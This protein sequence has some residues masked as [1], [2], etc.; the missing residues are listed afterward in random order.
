MSASV[1]IAGMAPIP[2]GA[3]KKPSSSR[4]RNSV[5]PAVDA[6]R[7]GRHARPARRP[8]RASRRRRPGRRCPRS[9]Q[10]RG[11]PVAS[12]SPRSS[13]R[14]Y[15]AGVSSRSVARPGGRRDRAAV[16]RAAMADR[17][18]PSR[19]EDGHD[20]RTAAERG[21]RVAAAD[22]LA[23]RRQVRPDPEAL[24]GAAGRDPERDDLVEDQQRAGP[25]G[26][27]RAGTAGRSG[28]GART[29]PA[30]WTGSMM[31]AA[32]SRSR[33]CSAAAMPSGSPHGSS[34]T[35]PAM[36][37][38]HPGRAGHDPVVRAVVGALELRPTSGRPVNAR[39]ARM[40]NMVASV[41]ELVNRSRSIEG[42]RRRISSASSTSVSVGA[43]KADPRRTCAS[44]AA[45][46]AGWAWPRISEV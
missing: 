21:E 16:E 14:P 43:A 19:V 25:V 44:T 31:I 9:D 26:E 15:V 12:R 10:R 41:P 27:R 20:V 38:R 36:R 11:R 33:P 32:R 22:D 46:T 37:L 17:A 1:A 35:S 45:T 18:R 24:L 5:G 28:S 39:A 40:A 3:R 2:R 8:G 30:P 7:E 6:G 42:T 13:S 4:P 23:E 29:P 34:T